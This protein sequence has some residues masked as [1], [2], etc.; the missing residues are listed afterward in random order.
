MFETQS[1]DAFFALH[2]LCPLR[3]QIEELVMKSREDIGG[4]VNMF[5]IDSF[6]NVRQT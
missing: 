1:R 5:L 4:K 6:Y 3:K 2:P